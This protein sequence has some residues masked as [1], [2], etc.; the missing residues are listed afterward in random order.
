MR[1]L[2]QMLRLRFDHPITSMVGAK[3]V[4]GEVHESFLAFTSLSLEVG[5]GRG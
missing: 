2:G 4:L 3:P 1:G 5:M